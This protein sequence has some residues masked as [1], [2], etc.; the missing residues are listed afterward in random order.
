MQGKNTSNMVHLRGTKEEQ[1]NTTN[2]LQYAINAF[3]YDANSE[4][5]MDNSLSV[6]YPMNPPDVIPATIDGMLS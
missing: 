2:A 3:R 5:N 6:P 1:Q 4:K